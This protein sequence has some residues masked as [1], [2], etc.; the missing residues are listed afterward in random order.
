MRKNVVVTLKELTVGK[1][2]KV[3]EPVMIIKKKKKGNT[4]YESR[5]EFVRIMRSF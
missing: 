5:S 2:K 1:Q 4:C 3:E